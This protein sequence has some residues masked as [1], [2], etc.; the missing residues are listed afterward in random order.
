MQN[1]QNRREQICITIASYG[2]KRTN[3]SLTIESSRI[4]RLASSYAILERATC[5]N[6]SNFPL[7]DE[8]YDRHQG[9]PV[10]SGILYRIQCRAALY[11]TFFR[12]IV[13]Q[14]SY[15]CTR[16]N[17]ETRLLR[18]PQ[19]FRNTRACAQKAI[20]I[21]SRSLVVRC[22]RREK[23]KYVFSLIASQTTMFCVNYSGIN[24]RSYE[25]ASSFFF[26]TCFHCSRLNCTKFTRA[27]LSIAT[28]P[29]GKQVV[30]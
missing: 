29:S 3:Y 23:L 27:S 14:T 7:F 17:Q 16:N 26:H 30:L 11:S 19:L 4:M 13:S 2:S 15:S 24:I 25:Y 18:V 5:S 8:S 28:S 10:I 20:S 12:H 9:I 21:I 6:S 1:N 22:N